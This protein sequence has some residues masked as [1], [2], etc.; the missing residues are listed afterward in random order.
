MKLK[1]NSNGK[2]DVYVYFMLEGKYTNAA[3]KSGMGYQNA[4]TSI[5]KF[6]VKP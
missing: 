4:S 2:L 1:K 3:G 6:E 5:Y